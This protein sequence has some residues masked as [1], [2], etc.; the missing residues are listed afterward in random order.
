MFSKKLIGNRGENS[1]STMHGVHQK[2]GVMFF[3]EINKNAVSC[4][5]TLRSTLRP[6]N[7]VEVARDN[8]KLIYPSDLDVS[9]KDKEL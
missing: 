6:S 4:W 9:V 5:N 7:V 8:E 1:Q 3:A 2:T